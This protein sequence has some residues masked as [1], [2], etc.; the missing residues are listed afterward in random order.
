MGKNYAVYK[1]QPSSMTRECK[2]NKIR[3]LLGLHS[4][5]IELGCNLYTA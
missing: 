5:V 1:L 4:L 2:P 3:I